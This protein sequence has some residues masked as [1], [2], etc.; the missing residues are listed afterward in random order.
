MKFNVVPVGVEFIFSFEG[1]SRAEQ[2][3]IS[4]ELHGYDSHKEKHYSY[5]GV[6]SGMKHFK[7]ARSAIVV[8]TSDA[9]RLRRFFRRWGVKFSENLVI[10]RDRQARKLGFEKKSGLSEFVDEV[11]G[12]DNSIIT[13]DF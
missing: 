6:L 5:K 4:R 9:K 2:P 1:L 13:V 7:P 10:L 3:K 8:S 11:R 12:D